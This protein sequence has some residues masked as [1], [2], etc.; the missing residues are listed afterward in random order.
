ME[1]TAY[2]A[3]QSAGIL[4]EF[5]DNLE[6][7]T[8]AS[9][10]SSVLRAGADEARIATAFISP[11]GLWQIAASLEAVPSVKLMLGADPSGE[12]DE[13][14]RPAEEKPQRFMRKTLQNR[15][16]RQ[17]A[18][19]REECNRMPFS[20]ETQ[21]TLRSLAKA[22]RAG[23][24]E[25]RRYV[26]R[27]LHAKAY[28]VTPSSKQAATAAT[29]IVGSSNLTK[30]GLLTNL[31]LNLGRRD[32]DISRRAVEWFD[33]LWEEAEPFELADVFE[34]LFAERTPFAIFVRIL[35]ELY[36]DEISKD[37]EASETLQL[38]EFQKHGVVRALRLIDQCGGAIVADEVGLGK[39]YIA[40]SII[41]QYRKQRQRALVICPAALISMWEDFQSEHEQFIEA[42][43]FE[44]LAKD[45]Q[46]NLPRENARHH[47]KRK[48]E[49]YQLVVIDEAHNYRNPDAPKRAGILRSLL[50]GQRKDLLLL[51][52]TPVNNS[53]WDLY[54]L[55]KYF[56]KQDAFFAD[57]GILS[58][59]ERF[60]EAEKT[61]PSNLSPDML[62]PLVDATTV[63][64]TRD[65]I[66][67]HYPRETIRSETGHPEEIVFPK[68]VAITVKYSLDDLM[69][70][71]Y[72]LVAQYLDPS[73]ASNDCLTF[74]RYL[75]EQYRIQDPDNETARNA[76]RGTGL[77]RVSMLKRFESSTDAFRITLTNMIEQHRFFLNSLRQGFVVS[78][79][80]I[81]EY[82]ASDDGDEVQD[83]Q[84]REDD[85]EPAHLFRTHELQADVEADLDRLQNLLA[86]VKGIEA[87]VDPK[88]AAL[89][90]ELAKIASQAKEDSVTREEA[91]DNRKV[92]VFSSYADTVRWIHKHLLLVTEAE[93]EQHPALA[94]Y[95]KRINMVVGSGAGEDGDKDAAARHFAPDTAGTGS[96]NRHDL[97]VSTDVLAE[98]VNLQQAR[99]IIN[100]DMPWNPMR[101]VQR[102]GRIDRIRSRHPKVFLRTIFP[103][104]R[105]NSLLKLVHRI[106]TKIARAAASVGVSSPIATIE[107]EDRVFTETREELAKLEQEDAT[108]FERGG[109][110]SAIQSG[111]EYR[112]TLRKAI[113]DGYDFVKD[114][115]W[116]SGSGMCRGKEQG[117]LYCA[118]IQTLKTDRTYL[119]FVPAD[120]EWK[121]LP[122]E[123][124]SDGAMRVESELGRC[125]R[126][127]ECTAEE[128][129][130][131]PQA[132][133]SAAIDLWPIARKHIH[134]QWMLETDPINLQ[135]KVRPLNRKVADH[136][137]KN[138]PQ[139][140]DQK[141]IDHALAIVEAPWSFRDEAQLRECFKSE[142]VSDSRLSKVLVDFILKT[143]LEPPRIPDTQPPIDEDGIM[144]LVWLAVSSG[145]EYARTHIGD[146][147]E[148][149]ASQ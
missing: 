113:Q 92:I 145:A 46:L 11:S 135:P 141:Q 47:L 5:I 107:G 112:Q 86:K 83:A 124:D 25:A 71:I 41:L 35:W 129:R 12:A 55:L 16:K 95:R 67:K 29:V 125:L 8:L 24:I 98:G 49:E 84:D 104:D 99:H 22:L 30:A 100:F 68:P 48:I 53:L 122:D 61:S 139:N 3:T 15:L 149:N 116:K 103:S 56:I 101:L 50:A 4:E 123:G 93:A 128:Q 126:I 69:H 40:G 80:F 36:Y 60:I 65:F 132:A 82:V 63:K 34:E 102:H 28:I 140:M 7:N 42:I 133:Q 81:Q 76:I 26:E 94:D 14:R 74:A 1:D 87:F 134:A 78:T 9:S 23:N 119:R 108:I 75:T 138:V 6:G 96:E 2:E 54:H 70:G 90:A 121:P 111:E 130:V 114:L 43:S 77:L 147:D 13:R 72:D 39:T 79:K 20:H 38:T 131:L 21:R 148:A 136:I 91:M 45:E 142:Q 57:K 66:V 18:D 62:Y 52:A 44:K 120:S 58:V 31:E 89:R 115:P 127:G 59:Y 19:L 144:L 73:D 88:L 105:L 117:I 32:E 143:G 137:R 27:F 64:R 146:A 51:T 109:T 85:S 37:L 110:A 17:Q 106:E 10:L 97:L 118:K 33:R